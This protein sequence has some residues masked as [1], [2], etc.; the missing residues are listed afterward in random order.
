MVWRV[1]AFALMS[2]QKLTS[3]RHAIENK[4]HLSQHWCPGAA[5]C[6]KST[7][8]TSISLSS[9]GE[10][11]SRPFEPMETYEKTVHGGWQAN[12]K[13]SEEKGGREEREGLRTRKHT[14]AKEG[15]T[16]GLGAFENNMLSILHV[17]WMVKGRMSPVFQ[18]A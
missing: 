5:C 15:Q 16:W 14:L 3:T 11:D 4:K 17:S 12:K 6:Q 7:P 1:T 10:G 13:P 18:E 8:S 2:L 9:S